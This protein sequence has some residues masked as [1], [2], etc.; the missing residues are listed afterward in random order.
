MQLFLENGYEK[1][2]TRQI[3]HRAGILNGSLYNLFESK[4]QIFSEVIVEMLEDALRVTGRYIPEDAPAVSR[5]SFPLC[6]L[7]YASGRD[8]RI[9]ELFAA[10]SL[11]WEIKQ[12][13][14]ESVAGWIRA[15]G[16]DAEVPM[17]PAEFN[18]KMYALMGALGA[19]I[20]RFEKQPGTIDDFDAACVLAGIMA[21]AFGLP[22]EDLEDRISEVYGSI[23]SRDI[24]IC[25]MHVVPDPAR[26]GGLRAIYHPRG[27]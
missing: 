6:L 16:L 17:E 2:T 8:R 13:V 27:H 15:N 24:V 7:I 21:G 14:T 3:T 22:A 19:V 4:D 25:G 23:A 18:L 10:A 20:E 12:R 26:D 9:A 11:R 5:M 1:T